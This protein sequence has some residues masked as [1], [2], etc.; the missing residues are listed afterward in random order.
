MDVSGDGRYWIHRF[1]SDTGPD[2]N[3]F[4]ACVQAAAVST[5]EYLIDVVQ[6]RSSSDGSIYT[7]FAGIVFAFQLA[8]DDMWRDLF[9]IIR[10][11]PDTRRVTFLQGKM[12]HHNITGDE[13]ALVQC[14][15]RAQALPPS[16]CELLYGRAG[17]LHGLLFALKAN[18][19]L[20][21]D[22][23]IHALVAQIV[24]AGRVPGADRFMWTWKGKEY[25]GA[26]HGVAGILYVLL[27]CPQTILLAVEPDI[28]RYIANTVDYVLTEQ[29]RDTGNVRSSVSSS[30]DRL[31]HFCHGATG[32][33][34]LLALM[35]RL[36]PDREKY[37]HH[38]ERMGVVVWTRGLLASKG[39]GLCHG[40][41]GSVCGL[42]DV[43]TATENVRWLRRAQWF[44]L[45]LSQN[46]PSMV[47]CADSPC[48]L[49]E[50]VAGTHYALNMV[51]RVGEEDRGRRKDTCFPGLGM[52]V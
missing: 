9:E 49:F 17:C 42:L 12:Y 3:E 44:A 24:R 33:I 19:A 16:E 13:A 7:G 39:P 25:L 29:V 52:G 41:A 14:A 8:N 10:N 37:L 50:G 11:V 43:Y 27:S 38:C 15:S 36:Y 46:W 1:P 2:R 35:A 28:Y 51:L 23:P 4:L 32:W 45:F 31:V 6:N 30:S 18:P 26:V 48:S 21:F 40:I 5:R 20:N 34:P 22:Q 47:E